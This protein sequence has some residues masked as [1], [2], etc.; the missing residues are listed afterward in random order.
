MDKEGE[1]IITSFSNRLIEQTD[2]T[3]LFCTK[4]GSGKYTQIINP[5]QYAYPADSAGAKTIERRCHAAQIAQY[6]S[7]MTTGVI[8][9][10]FLL[11]ISM[12]FIIK[13]RK[14]SQPKRCIAW[15]AAGTVTACLILY[16]DIG[17]KTENPFPIKTLPTSPSGEI[18]PVLPWEEM[19]I[20][21][22]YSVINTDSIEYS[23]RK[24]DISTDNIAEKLYSATAEGWENKFD[25][26]GDFIEHIHEAEIYRIN[27]ISPEC[28]VAVKYIGDTVYYPAVNSYY[29]PEALS[30]FV[31]GLNLRDNLSCGFA[32]QLYKKKLSGK[33]VTVYYEDVDIQKLWELLD[34]STDA[35]N[36]FDEAAFMQP[37]DILTVSVSIPLLG[38]ENFSV[39]IKEGGFVWTN[40]LDTGKMFYI[41]EEGTNAFVEY[42]TE[43]CPGYEIR[44]E[45]ENA[46]PV[47][48]E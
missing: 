11:C 31:N 42:V 36:V 8:I 18:A 6:F 44:F 3:Y 41:G 29:K 7:P 46:V 20:Y 34:S 47:I 5:D 1:I 17:Y 24:G 4:S 35:P 45:T 13:T 28:A 43:S 16:L 15:V 30:D 37:R 22:K 25:G 14:G 10:S 32:S 39:S 27:G 2:E 12:F 26:S 9:A 19:E 23:I 40:L 33:Y 21:Q 38:Y 48:P